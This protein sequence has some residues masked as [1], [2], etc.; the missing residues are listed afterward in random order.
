MSRSINILIGKGVRPDDRE[1]FFGPL[2][3]NDEFF[4]L[5][6]DTQWPQALSAVGLFRST[7]EARKNGWNRPIEDG[8]SV[9]TIG[10]LKN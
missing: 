7:S 8:F 4:A 1:L 10:K 6:D 5:P 3:P 2:T 9:F